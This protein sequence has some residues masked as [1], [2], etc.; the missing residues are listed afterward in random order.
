MMQG[1][2]GS[3]AALVTFDSCYGVKKKMRSAIAGVACIASRHAAVIDR[4]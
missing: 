1:I 4:H 2:N 3:S